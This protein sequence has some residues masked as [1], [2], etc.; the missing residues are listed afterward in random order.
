MMER[1]IK[2]I[3]CEMQCYASFPPVMSLHTSMPQEVIYKCNTIA[4]CISTLYA[5]NSMLPHLNCECMK[6][7]CMYT[8]S[9]CSMTYY[10]NMYAMQHNPFSCYQSWLSY[11]FS[12]QIPSHTIKVDCR[13]IILIQS[14]LMHIIC[15]ICKQLCSCI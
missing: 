6:L 3:I 10:Q 4:E 8:S 14:P 12:Y 5:T 11:P 13:V 2:Y 7:L 15:M 1:K 9:D